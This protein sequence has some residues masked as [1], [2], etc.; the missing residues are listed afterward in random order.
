MSGLANDCDGKLAQTNHLG[1][2]FTAHG[3]GQEGQPVVEW[4]AWG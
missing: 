4:I 2:C 3:N 1:I